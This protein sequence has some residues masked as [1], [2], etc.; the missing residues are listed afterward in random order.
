[1]KITDCPESNQSVEDKR[2][3]MYEGPTSICFRGQGQG[4]SSAHVILIAEWY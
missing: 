2:I 3:W 1:M 4:L